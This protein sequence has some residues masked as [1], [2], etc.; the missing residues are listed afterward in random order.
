MEK[1]I[2]CRMWFDFDCTD[3]IADLSR[4]QGVL[5]AKRDTCQLDFQFHRRSGIGEAGYF[6][7]S[8]T[9]R[10]SIQ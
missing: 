6:A 2:A 4:L 1:N 3:R 5:I 10:V 7:Y 9:E 8:N